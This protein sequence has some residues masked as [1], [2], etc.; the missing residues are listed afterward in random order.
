MYGGDSCHVFCFPY[1]TPSTAHSWIME[2]M[3]PAEPWTLILLT[4]E[5]ISLFTFP[6]WQALCRASVVGGSYGP[7]LGPR[8]YIMQDHLVSD[9]LL[10]FHVY[11]TMF[12]S[13]LGPFSGVG[14]SIS[15]LLWSDTPLYG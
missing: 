2:W 14:I 4:K 3:T 5:P 15:K 12:F 13:F 9:T 11:P 1:L 8:E 6:C 10:L 7:F